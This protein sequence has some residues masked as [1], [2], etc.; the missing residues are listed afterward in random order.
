VGWLLLAA[1][2]TGV[3]LLAIAPY[4]SRRRHEDPEVGRP[5]RLVVILAIVAVV[6]VG[7]LA[8]RRAADDHLDGLEHGLRGDLNASSQQLERVRASVTS[9]T[10]VDDPLPSLDG[11]TNNATLHYHGGLSTD[12]SPTLDAEVSWALA[13]RCFAITIEPGGA[14][15]MIEAGC[16]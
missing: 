16:R 8:W 15:W 10:S 1:I 6:G 9:S 3:V 13:R 4:L 11:I 7:N 14:Y 12:T 5:K 2:G